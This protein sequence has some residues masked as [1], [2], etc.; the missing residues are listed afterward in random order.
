MSKDDKSKVMIVGTGNVGM[1][2]GYSLV[3][4]GSAVNELVLTDINVPDAEGEALDLRDILAMCPHYM[5]I[6]AGTYEEDAKDTDIIIIT[7]GV[8]QAK[9][10]ETRMDLLRKNASILKSIVDPIMAS[11][12]DGVFVVVS[13]PLDVMT[14]LTWKF[15]GLDSSRVIGSG[16]VLDSA[17]LRFEVGRRLNVSPK[18]VNAY[19]VAEHGDT[20][21]SMWSTADLGGQPLTKIFKKEELDDI[22]QI[23]RNEA[24]EIINGKGATYYGIGSCVTDIINCI[25]AD[26]KRVLPISTYDHVTNTY[27][28]FPAILGRDGVVRK[29]EID[30]TEE[31]NIKLQ[32]SINAIS[33]A[34]KEAEEVAAENTQAE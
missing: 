31:E 8:P 5:N 22:E 6:H 27:Y 3:M 33:E 15:S 14:Y 30:M 10:G 18:S 11:G 21:F 2:I 1:S 13:N 7:A 24:Y 16:T 4:S 20:E 32:K 25:L 17:R 19:Q 34:I 23:A 28:G 29:L 9:G 26:E 12:F